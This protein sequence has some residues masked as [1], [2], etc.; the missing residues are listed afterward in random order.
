MLNTILIFT[1]ILG[2]L[3]ACR[4]MIEIVIILMERHLG[5]KGHNGA[6][7]GKL[8]VPASPFCQTRMRARMR[9][10]TR[11]RTSTIN[12]EVEEWGL[13]ID[14]Y[15][16]FA[17]EEGRRNNRKSW[18]NIFT[19]KRE[20]LTRH[21]GLRTEKK[22]IKYIID[23]TKTLSVTAVKLDSSRK[24]RKVKMAHSWLKLMWFSISELTHIADWFLPIS[25]TNCS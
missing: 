19:Q 22:C 18:T 20:H 6:I 7:R 10:K 4:R 8:W 17:D 3:L 13:E 2:I 12:W 23:Q 21:I 25:S 5:R 16:R 1:F 11:M 24:I 14:C 9:T 15:S